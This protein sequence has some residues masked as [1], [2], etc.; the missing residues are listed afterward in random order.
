MTR[1]F[2]RDLKFQEY[3]LSSIQRKV[4]NLKTYLRIKLSFI[5]LVSI[6]NTKIEYYVTNKT[7]GTSKTIYLNINLHP[8]LKLGNLKLEGK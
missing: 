7:F 6:C 5:Y 4:K 2:R 8:I 3:I 1:V